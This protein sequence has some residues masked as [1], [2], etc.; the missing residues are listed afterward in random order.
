MSLSFLSRRPWVLGLSILAGLLLAGVVVAML[1]DTPTTQAE[2]ATRVGGGARGPVV[3]LSA[4]PSGGAV[5]GPGTCIV[6]VDGDEVQ[7]GRGLSA[8]LTP[9]D[10]EAIGDALLVLPGGRQLLE[11]EGA[12]PD[13][14]PTDPDAFAGTT[15]HGVLVLIDRDV[16]GI[17]I[18]V[19]TTEPTPELDEQTRGRIDALAEALAEH[20]FVVDPA[21]LARPSDA[22]SSGGD[23]EGAWGEALGDLVLYLAVAAGIFL[24]A[25]LLVGLYH[26][27]RN[28]GGRG[29]PPEPAPVEE[30]PAP[31]PEAT[32]AELIAALDTAIEELPLHGDPR[33]VV[34]AAYVRMIGILEAHGVERR[35]SDTPL[36]LLARALEHLHTSGDAVRDLTR[37][38]E[39]A[40]FSTRPIDETMADDA[41]AALRRVRDEL[42]SPAWA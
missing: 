42:G 38:V 23:G 16:G 35:P 22:R 30:P 28:S 19:I 7:A 32:R 10:E 4:T 12:P 34:V 14:L 33:Q 9:E 17:R 3:H 26:V 20:G 36:E 29:T 25:G 24:A 31:D 5:V 40:L 1:E 13:D 21:D 39:L 18:Q 27:L 8:F 41:I 2:P 6:L 15:G 11:M 37:L